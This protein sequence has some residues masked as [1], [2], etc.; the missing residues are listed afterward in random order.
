MASGEMLSWLRSTIT[1]ELE[2]ARAADKVSPGPWVNRGQAGEGEAWQIH[3][4][5]T[6]DCE[7][8]WDEE[9]Q[10]FVPIGVRV[11]TLNYDDGGGVWEREAA[12]HIVL[13]QPRDTIARCEAGLALLDLHQHEETSSVAV[14]LVGG[15][16]Q[17]FG[18]GICHEKDQIVWG[19]GIC[20]T[21]RL[22]ASGYR[23]R[24][25]FKPEWVDG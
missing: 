8:E 3:G 15:K 17:P 13:Q 11:A 21:V 22:L 9:K 2:A 20:A 16:C 12:D 10:D 1:A 5:L 24:E 7:A 4:A 14:R 18:C 6:D 25:G 23:H 19:E